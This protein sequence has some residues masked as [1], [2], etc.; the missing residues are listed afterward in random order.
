MLVSSVLFETS[1]RVPGLSDVAAACERHGVELLVDAYHALGVVPFDPT[2]LADAWIVGGGYKYLQLGEGNCFL[3]LPPH[4]QQ[5]RP[6]ITGWFA[7]FAA[8]ADDRD[9]TL[10]AYGPGAT[11]F[12][13]STYDTTSHYRAARVLDFFAERGLTPDRLRAISLHQNTLL[14]KAFDDL[15]I[16]E[17][18]ATRDR[19]TPREA[20]G[21]FLSLRSPRTQ[22]FQ[23]ALAERGVLTDS[24]GEYLRF[25]PAPYLRDDQLHAA[26]AVLGEIVT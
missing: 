10:V 12:A 24:R 4:A 13:G 22:E 17:H 26:M 25:G 8:L 1:R 6:V 21:G 11:R 23:R 9:P 15:G 20:F 16:P 19:T 14:A 2:G 7:E 18:V 3:R 5:T